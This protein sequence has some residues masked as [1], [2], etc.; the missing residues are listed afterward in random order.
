MKNKKLYWISFS[1]QAKNQ[2]VCCVEAES[3]E[4]AK[5]VSEEL[6]L[7]PIN[8]DIFCAEI[9]YLESGMKLNVFYSKKEMKNIGYYTTSEMNI[10]DD[11]IK[12][13]ENYLKT[14]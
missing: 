6:G 11:C 9:P 10:C 7:I 5:Q 13:L 8:D 2:G 14:S 1:Y 4:E 3:S 12:D